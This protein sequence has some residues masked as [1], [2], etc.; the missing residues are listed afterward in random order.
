MGAAALLLCLYLSVSDLTPTTVDSPWVGGLSALFAL[1]ASAF[2]LVIFL[3]GL[4]RW[5]RV[6]LELSKML[7]V[8]NAPPGK[9]PALGEWP[10]PDMLDEP[11]RSPFN[12][13]MR[14]DNYQAWRQQCLVPWISQ[15]NALLAGQW[16]FSPGPDGSFAQWQAQLVAE[17]KLAAVAVRT[18]AWCSVLGATLALMLIQV[19]PP[20]YERVQTTVA[21]ILLGLGA[22]SIIYAVINLEK[23]YLLGRMFT[24]N[25]DSLTFGSVLSALWPKLLG[26]GGL[27]VMIFLPDAWEWLGGL[28]KAVNSLH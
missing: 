26:L 23:D 12:I 21:A 13:V 3:E 11:A 14:V 22:L 7:R 2:F 24:K 19:Y 25:K 8:I 18:A 17:M 27:L 28:I 9:E 5:R 6:S 4:D 1:G 16:P 10:T 20:V 15:T